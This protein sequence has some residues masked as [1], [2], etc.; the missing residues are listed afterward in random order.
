MFFEGVVEPLTICVLWAFLMVCYW[1]ARAGENDY[2]L[3]DDDQQ[4]RKLTT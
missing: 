1:N 2:F 4:Q 3:D